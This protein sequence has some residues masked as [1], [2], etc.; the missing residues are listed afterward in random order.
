MRIHK[1]EASSGSHIHTQRINISAVYETIKASTPL[2]RPQG[3]IASIVVDWQRPV[4][5]A[6]R[7]LA[8]LSKENL[9]ATPKGSTRRQLYLVERE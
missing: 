2:I 4:V 3:E 7:T 5:S 1:I 8:R 9:L 6:S